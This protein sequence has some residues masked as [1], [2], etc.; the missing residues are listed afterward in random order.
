MMMFEYGIPNPGDKAKVKGEWKIIQGYDHEVVDF[1]DGSSAF[2]SQVEE[3]QLIQ[4]KNQKV[5]SGYQYGS[6]FFYFKQ[7][8]E[9]IGCFAVQNRF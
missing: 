1:T 4:K 6:R 8:S 2:T 9:Q 7:S 5:E 3:V